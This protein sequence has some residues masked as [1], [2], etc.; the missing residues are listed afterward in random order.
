MHNDEDI[1]H[2]NIVISKN[3]L[4]IIIKIP[5]KVITIN[6]VVFTIFSKGIKKFKDRDIKEIII[7]PNIIKIFKLLAFILCFL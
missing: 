1:K 7:A 5:I 4:L 3:P 6:K 2:I